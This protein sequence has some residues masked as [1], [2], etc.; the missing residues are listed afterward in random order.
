[1]TLPEQLDHVLA[2][3][4]RARL[5]EVLDFASFL[6]WLDRQEAQELENWRR[7]GQAQLARAYGENEPDY[8][9]TE[10]KPRSC[11]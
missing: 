9:E 8:S 2:G 5:S 3:L 11:P 7:F 10:L 4:S 6:A 1:M